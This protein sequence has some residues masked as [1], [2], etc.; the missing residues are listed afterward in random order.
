MIIISLNIRGLNSKGKQRY[1]KEKLKKEKPSIMILQETKVSVQQLEEIINKNKLQYE[2]MGQDAIGSAGGIAI[3][4]NPND[5]ILE[6]WTS[7]TRILTGIGRIVGTKEKVVISGVYGPHT[8]GE[9]ESFMQNMKVIR[10][11]YLEPAWVIGGDFNL[12]RSLEEKKGG[13]RKADQYMEMFNDMIDEL[14]LVDIQTIN[15]I[16]T[17]NNRR[18]GKNQIALRLDRFL[19]SEPVMNKDVFV[20]AKIMPCLGS[21]HWPIRLEVDIKRNCGRR[22]FRFEIFWL[23]DLGFIKKMEEWWTQS[24]VQGKGKMHTFQ[25]KLKELKGRIKK[26]NKEE[27]GNILEEKQKLEGEMESLQHKIITEGRTEESIREEGIILG[28]LEER[29]KQEEVLWRQKSRIKWLREGE[30]NT[31]FFHQ[32]M[33]QHR[34]RNRILSIKDQ[35]GERVVEQEGIEK[36]LVEHHKAILVEPLVDKSEAIKEI[37]SAISRL[38]T[39][40]QNNALMRAANLEEIEEIVKSMKK[41]TAPGPDGFTIEFFQAGWHFLGRE[42]LE[43]IEESRMNQKVWPAINSTFYALIPKNDNLEDANGFR[44]IALCNVIYKIITTLIAKRLKPLLD[45]L[46]STEQMGFVEGRQILDGLVVTQEVIHSLKMKNQKGMMIK[47]DLSKAYDRLNW[48]YLGEVLESFGFKGLGR[49]IKKERAANKIKGLKLW[50]NELPLTHQQF[51]DDIMLFGEPTV[52]EVRQLKKILDLFTEASGLEINRDK[53]CVFIFNTMEQIKTHLIRLLGFKRGEL[54]TKYLGNLLDFTSKRLKN[55][56]GVLDKLRNRVVNWAFRTLNMAGRIVLVKSVLQAIPIYPL[57]IMAAHLGICSKIREIMRKFIWGGAN[58]QKK[59]ALVSWKHLTER[60][61]KGGL[62]LRDPEKLNKVLGAK[63]WWRWLREGNDLWKAIWRLKYNMPDTTVDILRQRETPKGS[64]IWDLARQNRDIVENHIFWEV[65][66]GGE[67]NFWEEKWQQKEK[68]NRIQTVQQLQEKIGGNRNCVK[69]YWKDNELDGIW[70][71]WIDPIEWDCDLNQE[72]QKAYMKE[73]ESRKIK[74]RTGRDILRWGY[75]MKGSFTVKEAY[76]LSDTQ[77]TDEENLEWKTIWGSK[78]WSKVSLFIWLVA[79]NKILTWD[80]IQ[81]KGFSGPS[82]CCLCK[83]AEENRN[84]L[85]INCSFTK[86]VW[87]D[88]RK[89]FGKSE[90]GLRDINAIIFQWNQ[91]KFQCKVVSGAWDLIAGFVLWMVW[92]ERNRRIF[93]DKAKDSDIIWKRAVSL[94]RETILVEKWDVED[95]KANHTE[96]MILNSLN[97][98]YEM[99]YHKHGSRHSERVQNPDNF[100]YPRD[101]FIKLNFDGASKGNPSNAGFGG[102]FHNSQKQVR[103][104]YAEWGGEMTNNEAELWAIHQGLRIAIRNG[105]TSLEIVG[106]S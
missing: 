82:R 22:P 7:M 58:H 28:K 29:R 98:K 79:K 80:R 77:A 16:C 83:N 59:W 78:W 92:K 20:E 101:N 23:R 73:G 85:L 15:G 10:R 95:W 71:K 1:M 27:F 102:I 90:I 105:Y 60:K 19:V 3:L 106:D 64:T 34:Q 4:W 52:K 81:K 41:G 100:I 103:W 31:K 96:E 70:R 93:Q 8:P 40:D 48:K 17:W 36:V 30:R 62:G 94:M 47:L 65:R 14:R 55:W 89:I 54:P 74:A 11:I 104:I 68:M 42:I 53:S 13:I 35:N 57:S 18:G 88:I 6:G 38:V 12:I 5:I 86:K 45:K 66:G 75:S 67:A 39:D 37:C 56:Q 49:Y 87:M 50:G 51:V 76:Y 24:S 69:D 26:W 63:L 84:H 99:V 91:E 9:K 61:E 43:L 44:P 2:V 33:I 72:Q 97:L 32:A 21:D 25:L 46:I